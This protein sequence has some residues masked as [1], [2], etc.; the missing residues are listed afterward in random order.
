MWWHG[1]EALF[2]NKDGNGA[3][4][5]K[6]LKVTNSTSRGKRIWEIHD[7]AVSFLGLVW[8]KN[9]SIQLKVMN[10]NRKK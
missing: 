2:R 8:R 1:L 3:H 10:G 6:F 9:Y 4:Q 7:A 5:T